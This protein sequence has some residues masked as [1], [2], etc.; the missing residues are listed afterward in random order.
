MVFKISALWSIVL[1]CWVWNPVKAQTKSLYD[2][3]ANAGADIAAAVTK[4]GKEGKHVF[5]QIGGNWCVWCLRFNKL[6]TENDTLK[7]A[8]DTGFV[9]VH[10]N[11]SKENKNEEVLASLGYP[12]R[13]GFPVFV[14]LDGKGK[15]LHTQNSA[16]LE[17]GEGHSAKKVLEFLKAWSPDALRSENYRK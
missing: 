14:I 10:V 8:I 16:Y 6:V 13:F 12:Q 4:A 7:K 5:L 1:L 15:R 11:Y 2:P 3:S 9:T 17:E